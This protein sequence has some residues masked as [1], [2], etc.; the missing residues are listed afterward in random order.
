MPPAD[1]LPPARVQLDRYAALTMTW[2]DGTSDV[3][4]VPFLR[5]Q[6]PCAT[7]REF[8]EQPQDPFRVL[9]EGADVVTGDLHVEAMTPVGHYALQFAFSDG[10]GTGIYSYEYLSELSPPPPHSG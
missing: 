3:Y 1:K 7:C 10:H 9:G 8:R 2:A 5:T 6:C 4:P